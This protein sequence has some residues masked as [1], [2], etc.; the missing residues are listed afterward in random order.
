M[1]QLKLKIGAF[2]IATV[3]TVGGYSF[4]PVAAPLTATPVAPKTA[5]ATP[6]PRL[7][8]ATT[9]VA[10]DLPAA[11]QQGRITAEFTS[12]SKYKLTFTAHNPGPQPIHLHIAG[13]QIFASEKSTVALVR[14]LELNVEPNARKS[15]DL[16]T[17]AT[18]SANAFGGTETFSMSAAKLPRLDALF[19]YLD[20]HAETPLA[21]VQT[22]VIVLTENLPV[23]AFAKFAMPDGGAGSR[24][25][26]R[27]LKADTCDIIAALLVLRDIGLDGRLALNIDPQLKI[28]AM[29]D[30]L[31]HAL[32][33]R[34]YGILDEWA[35]W[36]TELQQGNPATRHYALY[37]IGRFYP[38][39]AVQ[40]LPKW[41]RT[42]QTPAVFRASA[43][44]ALAETQRPE[45]LSALRQ[46]ETE[47]GGTTD[48]GKTAHVAANFLDAQFTKSPTARTAVAFRASKSLSEKNPAI[49]AANS[50][51]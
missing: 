24:L 31:A 4:M 49:A 12:D 44:Q 23:S 33:L 21:A 22:A 38:D 10:L 18:S 35:Y 45:A 51:E 43:I 34:Y 3:V 26:S 7:K 28:E 40:M 46:L 32:A 50:A 48:L 6:M 8:V 1:S 42:T 27:A 15:L 47:L 25:D 2:A 5:A 9:P 17:V 14:S 16:T 11:L 41:A 37:G 29:I 39:V 19:A 20:E 13:G 36:K 30:P